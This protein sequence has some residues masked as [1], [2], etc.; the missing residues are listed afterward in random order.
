[1][2]TRETELGHL[3]IPEPLEG[4]GEGD[5]LSGVVIIH[6][7]WGLGDHYRDV[8]GRFANEGFAA[9]ALNLYRG[10][11]AV[12][13]SDPG[14][15]MRELSDPDSRSFAASAKGK[16][17]RQVLE[18]WRGRIGSLLSGSERASS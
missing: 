9:L 2:Q 13:I 11:S 10:K 16:D 3:A 14:A 18:A 15:W 17:A 1:M 8:A 12:A 7:V 4:R 5:G 6:D